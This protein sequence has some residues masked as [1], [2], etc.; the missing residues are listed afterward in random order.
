MSKTKIKFFSSFTWENK[1]LK[2][3]PNLPVIFF[4]YMY[5]QIFLPTSPQNKILTQISALKVYTPNIQMFVPCSKSVQSLVCVNSTHST[6]KTHL[7]RTIPLHPHATDD[8]K[9]T[10][11]R[12][13]TVSSV[14]AVL[15]QTTVSR[16]SQPSNPRA[17]HPVTANSSVAQR[18]GSNPRY[19]ASLQPL[20]PFT[21]HLNNP[22][23]LS[24]P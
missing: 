12:R 9:L 3:F 13:G 2:H 15:P 5:T 16:A 6:P 8:L 23:P 1:P 17:S 20:L 11:S 18:T 7:A 4:S 21:W 14:V 24:V 19:E 22:E 10:A